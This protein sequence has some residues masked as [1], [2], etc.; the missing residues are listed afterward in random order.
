MNSRR[1]R[2][3][4]PFSLDDV[5]AHRRSV[6]QHVDQVVGK[7]IHFVDVDDAAMGRG[8]Q[9]GLKCSTSL[10]QCPLEIERSQHAVFSRTQGKIH[11]RRRTARSLRAWS[12]TLQCGQSA[13][14]LRDRN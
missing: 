3:F 6:E 11:K 4:D 12:S 13:Q 8:Q 2:G 9:P 7:Q 10:A 14:A 5:D 1:V